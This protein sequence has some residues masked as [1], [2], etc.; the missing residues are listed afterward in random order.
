M[1]VGQWVE[2][3]AGLTADSM[4]HLWVDGSGFPS[5]DLLVDWTASKTAGLTVALL[6]AL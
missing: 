4:A 1:S 5:V 6:V 2:L 3:M